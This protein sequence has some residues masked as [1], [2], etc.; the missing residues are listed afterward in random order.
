MPK[1]RDEAGI[2]AKKPLSKEELEIVGFLENNYETAYT[3][4]DLIKELPGINKEMISMVAHALARK[5]IIDMIT[6]KEF[7]QLRWHEIRYYMAK[8]R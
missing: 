7:R 5:E 2:P 4:E 3:T 6:E 1:P 8:K